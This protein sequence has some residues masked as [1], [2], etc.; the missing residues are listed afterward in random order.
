MI[1]YVRI[2]AY[3]LK[4]ERFLKDAKFDFEV[5]TNFKTKKVNSYY[6]TYKDIRIKINN[7]YPFITFVGSLHKYYC[8]NNYSQFSFSD[9][10]ECIDR[11]QAD[12]GIIPK[13]TNLKRIEFGV[14][15]YPD[16]EVENISE[17]IIAYK[18]SRFCQMEKGKVRGSIGIHCD[19]DR[20]KIKIYDK[21][22]HYS[23]QENILR[24]E[25]VV[26]KMVQMH[27]VWK[28]NVKT[29]KDLSNKSV[30]I[31][32][33]QILLK[34]F[35]KILLDQIFEE[36]LLSTKEHLL[37]LRYRN[38]DSF[39]RTIGEIPR[40]TFN[41]QVSKFKELQTKYG[42]DLKTCVKDQIYKSA[43]WLVFE[44][45]THAQA[46]PEEL[47]SDLEKAYGTYAQLDNI[48]HFYQNPYSSHLLTS[49]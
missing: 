33:S 2:E 14:N 41:N 21:A 43:E 37:Y 48:V 44:N 27:K 34:T 6:C 11:L 29:L 49:C 39:T 19:M 42:T 45:S 17:R 40:S 9:F 47:K 26:K 31:R 8:G 1:D 38:S 15:I 10:L 22:K 25:I 20:F 7:D 32:L 46:K 24:Y 23:L 30:W 12:F 28:L 13:Q 36:K 4:K 3:G 16:L 18:R 35:D 5:S